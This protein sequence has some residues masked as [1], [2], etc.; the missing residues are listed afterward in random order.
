M[1]LSMYV[2]TYVRTDVFIIRMCVCMCVCVCVYV[3]V[4]VCV[5]MYIARKRRLGQLRRQCCRML[6]RRILGCKYCVCVCVCVCNMYSLLMSMSACAPPA[7]SLDAHTW[8]PARPPAHKPTNPS[9]STRQRQE[10]PTICYD[11]LMRMYVCMYTHTHTHT[12][13]HI[14]HR[15]V[16]L[17]CTSAVRGRRA[18]RML[19][20][21]CRHKK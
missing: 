8:P 3:Y 11:L 4:Y 12:H 9:T 14:G 2:H 6:R 5:Y 19:R 15:L 13:I 18:T 17:P 1:Y 16:L 21:V 7:L 20:R 10:C